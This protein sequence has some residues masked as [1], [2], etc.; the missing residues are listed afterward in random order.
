QMHASAVALWSAGFDTTVATLRLC[1]LELVNNPE[2]Q[3]KLQK[4][5]DGVIGKRRIRFE[6]REKLP[7]LSAFLQEVYRLLNVLPIMFI[8]QTSQDTV[9]EG[10]QIP[11]G[12]NILPQFS[13]VHSDPNE[14]ERPEFFCPD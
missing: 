12:T 6:D 10:W 4:E 11:V 8:R 3:R 14:F 1:C 13:M 7:Y 5:I 9:I 2:V